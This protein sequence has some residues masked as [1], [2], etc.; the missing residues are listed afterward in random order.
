[1]LTIV[2]EYNGYEFEKDEDYYCP[3]YNLLN[4]LFVI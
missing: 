1:M 3:T 2:I 4:Q